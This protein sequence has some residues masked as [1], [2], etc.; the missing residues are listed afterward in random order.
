M[1]YFIQ[2]GIGSSNSKENNEFEVIHSDTPI[3][4]ESGEDAY[5]DASYSDGVETIDELK[6]NSDLI[7]KVKALSQ[8]EASSLATHTTVKVIE[9]IK[10]DE[11]GG[12]Q[13][14]FKENTKGEIEATD[15][16]MGS[17]LDRIMNKKPKDSKEDEFFETWAAE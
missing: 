10:G 6:D 8:E 17:E 9:T 15:G 16:S 1:F 5:V 7:V 12:I 3:Y 14:L 4:A 11:Y 2:P 13:G